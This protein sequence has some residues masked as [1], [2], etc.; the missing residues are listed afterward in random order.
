MISL[1]PG[2]IHVS[3]LIRDKMVESAYLDGNGDFADD[4]GGGG[5]E[6]H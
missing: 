3:V 4:S 6:G 5:S 1:G 2:C